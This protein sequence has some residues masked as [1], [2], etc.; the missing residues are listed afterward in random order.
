VDTGKL[1]AEWREPHAQIRGVAFSPDGNRV[2]QAASGYP[3]TCVRDARTGKLLAGVQGSPCLARSAAAPFSTDGQLLLSISSD[4]TDG[5]PVLLVQDATDA[6]G[7]R[8]LTAPDGSR[9]EHAEPLPVRYTLRGHK[10]TIVMA[11]FSPDGKRIASASEDGTVRVW[12][13]ATGKEYMCLRGHTGPVTKVV[14]LRDGKR[15]VSAGKDGAVRVW[16]LDLLPLAVARAP[17]E[18]TAD[19]RA[20]FEIPE[21]AKQEPATRSSLLT[22]PK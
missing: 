20:R 7:S 11:T 13:T 16:E 8:M 17:R 6:R 10:A 5:V 4:R 2:V 22:G 1:L 18:L 15:V 12:E 21:G 14:F 3:G 9:V 19:E